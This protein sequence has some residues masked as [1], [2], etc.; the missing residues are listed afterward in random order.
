MS[1][2]HAPSSR[3]GGS[4]AFHHHHNMAAY[5]DAKEHSTTIDTTTTSNNSNGEVWTGRPLHVPIH[6]NGT[7]TDTFASRNEFDFTPSNNSLYERTP[8][9]SIHSHTTASAHTA[10]PSTAPSLAL[11]PDDTRLPPPLHE[12]LDTIQNAHH[13]QPQTPHNIMKDSKMAEGE[14]STQRTEQ[15]DDST[16]HSESHTPVLEPVPTV[17]ATNNTTTVLSTPSTPDQTHHRRVPSWE[18]LPRNTTHATVDDSPWQRVATFRHPPMAPRWNHH[19]APRSPVYPSRS[20]TFKSPTPRNKSSRSNA[21]SPAEVLKTL[22]RKKACLYEPDTSRAVILVTWLVGRQLTLSKGYF[23]RQELQAG[24][25]FVLA[26]KMNAVVTRTKVNRCMQII[27]N[28]CFHYIIPRPDGTEESGTEFAASFDAPD[29]SHL[30]DTLPAPWKGLQVTEACLYVKVSPT[31]TPVSSPRLT[32]TTSPPASPPKPPDAAEKRAVLLCFNDNCR[33]AAHIQQCHMEFIMDTAHAAHL[34]LT[35]Q[36]WKQFFQQQEST[37]T[38]H[39]YFRTSWC[40]KRY[41][42]DASVCGFAHAEINGGWLRR[43]GGYRPQLCTHVQTIQDGDK[44]VIVN[45]CKQGMKC[46]F[47]HSW[48]EVQYPVAPTNGF[49]LSSS[50]TNVATRKTT[51]TNNNKTP[52]SLFLPSWCIYEKVPD[53]FSQVTPGLQQLWERQCHVSLQRL[54]HDKSCTYSLFG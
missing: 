17:T 33:S 43:P 1:T 35:I 16:I 32:S 31:T 26:S 45:T 9:A 6:A 24:V 40:H 13:S 4:A 52:Q 15:D 8:D 39:Y 3:A 41:D 25:H 2:G 44:Y 50:N 18:G 19:A 42:H 47:A 38:N 51:T 28:S 46:P 14:S 20:T 29:E 36:E 27:L 48:E 11:V 22:L 5:R 23:S 7:R 49:L 30:L 12:H 37:M 34:H 10:A 21:R 53:S 54:L